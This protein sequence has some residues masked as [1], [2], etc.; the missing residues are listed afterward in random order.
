[1]VYLKN[2]FML[3][4]GISIF[5][6]AYANG[7]CMAQV[8]CSNGMAS[9]TIPGGYMGS[10]P[11]K[12]YDAYCGEKDAG[13]KFLSCWYEA[14]DK[15]DKNIQDIICCDRNGNVVHQKVASSKIFDT[16]ACVGH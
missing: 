4:V 15:S 7:V 1:M 10:A 6:N 2:I 16:S 5:S 13:D 14:A 11:S 9:C 8:R 12:R 3:I